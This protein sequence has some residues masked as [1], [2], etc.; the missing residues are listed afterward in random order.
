M[1]EQEDPPNYNPEYVLSPMERVIEGSFAGLI[2]IVGI[3][4]QDYALASIGAMILLDS[5]LLK[6]QAIGQIK[7]AFSKNTKNN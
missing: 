6:G 4:V 2:I 7:W 1:P 3:A 5:T